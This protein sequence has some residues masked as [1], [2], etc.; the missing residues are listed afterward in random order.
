MNML[1]ELC[2]LSPPEKHKAK[3]ENTKAKACSYFRSMANTFLF[4]VYEHHKSLMYQ[5]KTKYRN[6]CSMTKL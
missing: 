6:Q 5:K 2:H 1:S 4:V 3:L